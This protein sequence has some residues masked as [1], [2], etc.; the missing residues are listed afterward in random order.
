MNEEVTEEMLPLIELI[1][2]SETTY[3]R[4]NSEKLL[5]L[6]HWIACNS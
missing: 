5:F 2:L 1:I 6:F 3:G 4:E